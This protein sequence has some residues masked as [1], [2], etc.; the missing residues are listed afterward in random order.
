MK[1]TMMTR[2]SEPKPIG[3]IET[4]DMTMAVYLISMGI[5]PT[6]VRKDEGG[7]SGHPVGAWL[8]PADEY[9][10][11]LI[12]KFAS[13]EGEVEPRAFHKALTSARNDLFKFLGI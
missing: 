3:T 1:P 2:P 10:R 4:T 12:A 9:T 6:L 11:S 8:F 13:G 5:T 7:G